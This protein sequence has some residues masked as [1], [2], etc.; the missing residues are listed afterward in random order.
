MKQKFRKVN[1]GVIVF[2]EGDQRWSAP[3]PTAANMNDARHAARYPLPGVKPNYGVASQAD[4]YVYLT[5]DCP[6][7]ELAIEKLRAIRRAIRE[8]GE[9]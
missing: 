5:V 2:G 4:I 7:T 6:T 9:S 8:G 3:D 1:G